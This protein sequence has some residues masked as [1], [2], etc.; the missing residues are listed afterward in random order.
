MSQRKN[1]SIPPLFLDKKFP[2]CNIY[3]QI[4]RGNQ[5][6]Q[7]QT[8]YSLSNLNVCRNVDFRRVSGGHK[9]SW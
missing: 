4:Q 7:I 6:E 3:V 2:L 8:I 9:Q 5:D 1:S